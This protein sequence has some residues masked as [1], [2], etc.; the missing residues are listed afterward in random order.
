MPAGG[1]GLVS[2]SGSLMASL[3][4]HAKDLGTGFSAAVSVGNQADLEI[5]DFIEYFWKIPPRARSVRTWKASRT[6]RVF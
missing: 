2:Q 1:I 5:C 3:I 6:A 4:S